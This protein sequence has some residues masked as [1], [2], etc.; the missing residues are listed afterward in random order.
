MTKLRSHLGTSPKHITIFQELKLLWPSNPVLAGNA[1]GLGKLREKEIL[2]SAQDL[3]VA[4][5][6]TPWHS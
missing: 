4:W 1:D 5:R 2:K 6:A 3:K